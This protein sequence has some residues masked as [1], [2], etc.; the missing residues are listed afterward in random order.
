MSYARSFV[1]Y[2][3]MAG[4]ATAAGAAASSAKDYAKR[5]TDHEWVHDGVRLVTYAAVIVAAGIGVDRA[6]NELFSDSTRK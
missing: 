5:Q 3:A 6:I 1:R 4:A 2:L